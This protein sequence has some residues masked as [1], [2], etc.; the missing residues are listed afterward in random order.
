MVRRARKPSLLGIAVLVLA[1]AP[2]WVGLFSGK[3]VGDMYLYRMYGHRMQHGLWPYHDFYFDWAPGSV[4]PV[5]W[6]VLPPGSYYNWFHVFDLVYAMGAIAAVAVTL[7][8]LGARGVRLY[9]M[10]AAAAAL[11]FALGSISIN[12][13]DYWPALFTAAGLAALLAGRN[14]LGFGL[15]GFGIAAKVYPVV[16]LPIVLVW[17]WR[18]Y[19]RREALRSLWV[20]LGVGLVASLPFA[21]VGL[22]GLG[23][24]MKTQFERGLQMESLPAT[25]LMAGSRLGI[26]HVHVVVGRPYSLNVAGGAAT[27]M[28][29]IFTLVLIAALI[30][31]YI[32]YAAGPDEPQRLITAA[33]AAVTAYVAFNRVLSPQYIV[34]LI[35][36]VPLVAG[37][38]GV[39]ATA[40][41][42]GACG[43]TM[44]WF[45]GRFWHLVH[46]SPVTWFAL[47]R[48]VLL[49]L[50]FA[51]VAMP[52]V[53]SM[54]R[55]VSELFTQLRG[56]VLRPT[57]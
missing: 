53:R 30:G 20:C 42:F 26:H 32:A 57:S 45:P 13:L 15:L 51:A 1:C 46:V 34:W 39:V 37:T 55:P 7:V 28:A 49:V 21:I 25:I 16:L 10:V 6:P 11:P 4:L 43:L 8:A 41:L 48:N 14:R 18:R 56:A 22:T 9:G 52:L 33:A 12:S 35:P 54:R 24:S 19:G 27:V 31:V 38:P 50:V 5:L 36:L 44:T 29:T 17:A 47:S 40:L 23:Y 2:P 3:G